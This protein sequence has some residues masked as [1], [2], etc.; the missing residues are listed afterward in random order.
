MDHD[1]GGASARDG[2]E[3][4]A[5]RLARE[6][7]PANGGDDPQG[8]S[9]G[10]GAEALPE[11]GGAD[12]ALVERHPMPA[13][14]VDAIVNKKLLA[15][16]L[17]VSATTIDSWL[18]DGLP[19][20]RKGTN[21]QSYE[22]RLSVCFAWAADRE[23]RAARAEAQAAEAAQQL[24]L[25]LLGG[26]VADPGRAGMTPRE[27]EQAM[28][29]ELV[30]MKLA[31]ARRDLMRAQEV[32]EAFEAAFAAIRDGIDAAPDILGRELALDGAGIERAQKILDGLLTDAV[33]LVAERLG[34]A[35]PEGLAPAGP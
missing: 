13:G 4:D 8:G 10:G 15:H 35:P 7:P 2:G 5:A 22:F 29:A 9:G 28:A 34:I 14:A 3:D 20:V 27:A 24:R 18:V 6:V 21:G 1:A 19:Y 23:A 17:N 12:R 26:S 31:E 16:A 11:L 32:A 33:R 30:A 25:Q